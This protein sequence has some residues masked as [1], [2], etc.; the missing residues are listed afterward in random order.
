MNKCHL[1]QLHIQRA[2]LPTDPGHG[3]EHQNGTIIIL[4]ERIHYRTGGRG[5][6]TS[7]AKPYTYIDDIFTIWMLAS[8]NYIIEAFLHEINNLH[9]TI[10]FMAEWSRNRVSLQLSS[11]ETESTRTSSRSRQTHTSICHQRV[12]TLETQSPTAKP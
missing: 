2:T 1:Q 12:A 7:S 4:C 8:N 6:S 3:D 11:M 10:K 9:H 5:C